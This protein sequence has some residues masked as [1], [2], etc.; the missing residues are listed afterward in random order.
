[1]N[2]SQTNPA[3]QQQ[4]NQMM[5]I[6]T[7]QRRV[8]SGAGNFFWIAGLSVINSLLYTFGASISFVIGLGI[9]Q[10]IDGFAG[11]LA[12]DVKG[13]TAIIRGVGLVINI[14]IALIFVAFGFFAAKGNRAI[15]IVGMVLY[16][17]DT[18]L[19]LIFSAWMGFLF[20]LLFL[21]FLFSGLQALSKLKKMTSQAAPI[22]EIPKTPGL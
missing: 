2:T 5:A 20:H 21:W 4:L 16:G 8:K 13:G 19:M 14:F 9:A 17:L 12:E 10:F 1:M 11:A 18:L 15:Y 6:A 7:L 22:Y 3:D